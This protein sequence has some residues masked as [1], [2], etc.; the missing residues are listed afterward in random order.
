MVKKLSVYMGQYRRWAVLAPVLVIVEVICE[1][2]MPRLMAA[3]VDV[4]IAN[5]D[6]AYIL[7]VGGVMLALAAVGMFCGVTSAK[8]ASIAG[9]GFGANL[10]DSMFRKIQDF[11]FADIDRFS[12]GSLITRMTN[13]VNAI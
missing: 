5:S 1:I 10:R 2:I 9:Q 3:I 4:G 8:A 13:D 12:S 11:S 7:R 6:M